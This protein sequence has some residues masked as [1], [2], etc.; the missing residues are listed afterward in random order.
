MYKPKHYDYRYFV[1]YKSINEAWNSTCLLKCRNHFPFSLQDPRPEW[2][3]EAVGN[4][5]YLHFGGFSFA[6]TIVIAVITA[7]LTKP[8]PK[9]K[10]LQNQSSTHNIYCKL[11]RR[12][13]YLIYM[14]CLCYTL[15]DV[16]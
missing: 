8:I 15:N 7:L 1:S 4:F 16:F 6:F 3:R 14:L 10:V 5:H 9:E 11:I 13:S 2:V 12:I